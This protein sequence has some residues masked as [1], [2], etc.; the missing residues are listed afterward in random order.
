MPIRKPGNAASAV[1]ATNFWRSMKPHDVQYNKRSFL[2]ID[3]C[4]SKFN[5]RNKNQTNQRFIDCLHDLLEQTAETTRHFESTHFSQSSVLALSSPEIGASM[6]LQSISP[7]SKNSMIGWSLY[8]KKPSKK[9]R[10]CNNMLKNQ[11]YLVATRRNN[12]L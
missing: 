6:T 8:C 4:R 10:R 9:Q 11:Y 12:R 5:T 7:L 1:T 2:H 3:K